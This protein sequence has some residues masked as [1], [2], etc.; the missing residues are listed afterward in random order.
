MATINGAT[1]MA[2]SLK[3]QGVDYM[4]GIVGFPVV[5]IA[6]AAQREGI[7]FIGMRNEQAASYATQAA[8]YL[9]GRPQACLVVSGPGVIHALS[10]LANAQQN[11]WPMLLIGGAS[12]IDQNGMGGFQE[13]RQVMVTTPFTK[14]SHLV[15]RTDRIPYYVEQAI[16]TAWYGRP[17]AA[18][19]DMPDDVILGRVE[20]DDVKQVTT[21]PPPPRSQAADADVEAALAALKTAERP[22][23]IVGKGMAWSRAEGEVRGFIERTQLPFLNS[24]MGKGVMPDDHPLSVGAARSLALKDADLVLLLGARLNWIM[25][26]GLP[27]RFDPKVRVIQLDISPEQLSTNVPTEVGLV[28]DG[29]AVM[30]QLN[31]ALDASAWQYPAATPWRDAIAAKIEANRGS[32]DAMAADDALPMNYYRAFRDIKE[33]IPR[34][35]IIVSEGANTMDIGRTQLNNA[36]PRTRLDAGSYGTMGVGF[37]FAVAAAVVQSDRPVVSVSGDSAFGFSGME[38]ETICR[39]QLPSTT[40]V[41]NNGGIGGG[42]EDWPA[43]QPL[44]PSG[45]SRTARYEKV[46]EAF[47][48]Q[49]YYV[50]D[51]ADLRPT[52]DKAISSGKPSVVHV[53][54]AAQADRK[55]Q[56]F[57]WKT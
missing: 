43:D 29:R 30:S 47:G 31:A 27:P 52:L 14:Y 32:I 13:E 20:E 10:G 23:V 18:Y 51:P 19:L 1:L 55:P 56:E 4:F 37:G 44:P 36:E 41:L 54:I 26:F 46:I 22:L 5:P 7:T 28:G 50:E 35:A 48:G 40:I 8:G 24:P 2:R 16:R 49:G 33:A 34:D 38:L 57:H 53:L 39:Y 12:G 9:L 45:L 11:N 15:E 21:T 17:G 25:H 42:F 3:Q 6:I